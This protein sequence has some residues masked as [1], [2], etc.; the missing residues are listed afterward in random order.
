MNKR[1]RKNR[2]TLRK[3]TIASL[4]LEIFLIF[5]LVGNIEL[6]VD[7][8]IKAIIFFILN[9]IFSICTIELCNCLKIE[10]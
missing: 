8:N 3:I 9:T 7:T 6:G 1:Q 4:V 10:L 2:R 5:G